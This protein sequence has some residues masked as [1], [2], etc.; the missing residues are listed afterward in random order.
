MSVALL[1][2]LLTC[3][4]PRLRRPLPPTYPAD[5]NVYYSAAWL[6]RHGGAAQLYTGADTGIDPQKLI[7][8]PSTPIFHAAQAEGLGFVGLYLYPPILADLLVPLTFVPL[9]T[10][11]RLWYG[12]N[13][14]LLLG[15]AAMLASLLGMSL[16][17]WSFALLLLPALCFTPSLQCLTDGQITIVLLALWTLGLLLYKRGQLVFA[18]G[19]FALAAA[20]KLTPAVVL[21]PLLIWRQWKPLAGFALSSLV[22]A[23]TCLW[24]NTPAAIGTYVHRVLPAMS[25]AIASAT[26]YSLPAATQRFITL[27]RTGTIPYTLPLLP[28]STVLAGR[29]ASTAVLLVFAALLWRRR[30]SL[31]STHQVL[32][33]GLLALLAPVVSPV[34]WFHAYATAF[35][36][37]AL[38]W[39]EALTRP[40]SNTFLALLVLT[41][42]CLGTALSENLL[43][44]LALTRAAPLAC[45]LQLAQLLL[46][47][48]LVCYRV[49]LLPRSA[50]HA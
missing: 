35:A 13:I 38:L 20:I 33:L 49:W 45:L 44:A 2:V 46:A 5:F 50:P 18:G 10:A 29:V 25:G 32:V 8:A 23:L 22:L 31:S 19:V 42:L 1:L 4:A 30:R 27:L 26:N 43:S 37:L 16:R 21:L 48:S 34:S 14:A 39:W 6:V 28:P 17:K 12:L 3:L 36:A 11:A 15:T 9:A 40:V 41:S 7:A 47:A 24:I